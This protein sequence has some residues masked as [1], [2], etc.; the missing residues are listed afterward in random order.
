MSFFSSFVESLERDGLLRVIERP[1]SPVSEVTRVAGDSVEP[2]LFTD[3][4]GWRVVV[5]LLG[6]REMLSRALGIPV[7]RLARTLA[8]MRS[9]GLLEVVDEGHAMDAMEVDLGGLPILT[10]H[11]GDGG[12][13]ITG[14]VVISEYGG[15]T[16]ASIHRLMVIGRDKLVARIVEGRHTDTLYQMARRDGEPLPVA[17]AIGVDPVTLYAVCTRVPEGREFQFA[18]AL[19]GEPVELFRSGNGLMVPECEFLLE[20]YLDPEEVHSEGPFVDITGTYDSVREQP[21]IQITGISRSSDPIYHAILPASGEHRVLMGVPYEP[22]I[23][24]EASRFADVRNVV[25]S[26]GGC[27]YLHAVVQIRKRSKSEVRDVIEAAFRAHGSLKHVVVVD[28][29]IDIL[30]P[31]DVE[32]A[33][34]T[35]VQADRDI[36]IYRGQRGSSLDPSRGP[37]GRTAKMGVDATFELERRDEYLRV[38]RENLMYGKKA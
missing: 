2:L 24:R 33:I 22:L 31:R 5:N 20:G 6:T 3:V 8:G 29:D 19:K 11:S 16:N 17:I 26:D 30:D 1:V 21:V 13:Y 18:S 14:G 7:D 32:Y 10:H 4:S 15:V 28:E 35:R 37:D 12:A 36:H 38:D 9:D 27:S 34:A 25:M 23:Y